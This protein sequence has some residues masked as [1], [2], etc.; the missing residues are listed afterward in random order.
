VLLAVS[1]AAEVRPEANDRSEELLQAQWPVL[2]AVYGALLEALAA[3]GRLAREEGA[4]RDPAP[5]GTLAR[6]RARAFFARS[7]LRAT[8]RWGKYVALYEDW[9]DYALAKVER[10]SGERI[11]LT[12]RERRWP[13]LFLWP[14]AIGYL[15]RRPQRRP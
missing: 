2:G 13:L 7:K 5:P 3:D 1:Y 12:D 15:R 4:F 14:R 10:R 11:E 6:A 9:L 8:L